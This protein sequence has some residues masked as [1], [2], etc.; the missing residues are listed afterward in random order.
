MIEARDEGKAARAR[1]PAISW[2]EAENAAERGRHPDRTVGVGAERQWHHAA[3]DC[4]AAAARR[5]AGHARRVMRIT[6]GTVVHVLA[7]EIVSVF[8]HVERANEHRAGRFQPLDQ[9]RVPFRR[10]I[11][12]VDLG[13]GNGGQTGNI[14]QVLHRE[15]YAGK[16]ADFLFL[17]RRSVDRLGA[18]ARPLGGDGG[19]G[20]E[21]GIARVNASERILGH[22]KSAGFARCNRR[23]RCRSQSPTTYRRPQG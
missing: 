11:G 7:G 5:A 18:F 13:A 2:L 10:R 12:A 17:R 6:R 15:R 8:A 4:A 20:I 3:G 14:E 21:R 23:R 9:R 16:R 19:E 1:Q 22:G